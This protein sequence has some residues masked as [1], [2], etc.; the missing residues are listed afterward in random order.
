MNVPLCDVALGSEGVE[1]GYCRAVSL[2]GV[3]VAVG[4]GAGAQWCLELLCPLPMSQGP[5]LLSRPGVLCSRSRPL[6]PASFPPFHPSTQTL[7]PPLPG[8]P[9][10]PRQPS[11]SGAW[12][13]SVGF[14]GFGVRPFML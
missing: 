14:S 11:S 10:A 12:A 4:L 5:P 6:P 8:L 13:A 3:G 7:A 1:P 2:R 9:D